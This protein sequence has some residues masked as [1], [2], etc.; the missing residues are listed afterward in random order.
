MSL[1]ENIDIDRDLGKENA[2]F[3][4]EQ[5]RLGRHEDEEAVIIHA[6]Q[7]MRMAAEKAA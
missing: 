6:I 1:L 7:Q 5:V 2:A 3:V 4:R